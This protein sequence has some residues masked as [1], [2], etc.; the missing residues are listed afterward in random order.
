MKTFKSVLCALF[1]IL[2]TGLS[3]SETVAQKRGLPPELNQNSSLQEI[4]DYLDKTIFAHARIGFKY[5]GPEDYTDSSDPM[6]SMTI[7]TS[8]LSE[9]FVLSQGFRL[10]SVDGCKFTLKNDDVQ[11]AYWSTRSYNLDLMSF[12]KFVNKREKGEPPL[13]PKSAVVFI[14]LDKMSYRKGKGPYRLTKNP[15]EASQIGTWRTKFQYKGFFVRTIFGME[16]YAAEPAQVV[17]RTEAET[18]TFTFDDKEMSEKF[19]AAFRQA[20]RICTAK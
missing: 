5:S 6:G 9:E 7:R 8:R 19:N 2:L 11:I 12:A 16:L 15:E 13:T 17:E 20:I 4:L 14:P 10:A 18:L 1:L 3:A